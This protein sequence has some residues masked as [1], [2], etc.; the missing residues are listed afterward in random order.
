MVEIKRNMTRKHSHFIWGC[1]VTEVGQSSVYHL[2][3]PYFVLL[4]ALFS[5][6]GLRRLLWAGER[7]L[8]LGLVNE[9]LKQR[10]NTIQAFTLGDKGPGFKR[11]V[12]RISGVSE[13]FPAH[14]G[15]F[16]VKN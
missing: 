4:F 6:S 12:G 9:Y 16:G 11:R 3:V 8:P 2:V 13:F 7:Y 10:P 15:Y 5:S 1:D 14:I